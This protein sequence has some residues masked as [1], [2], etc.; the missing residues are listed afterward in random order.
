[1]PGA[2]A[3]KPVDTAAAHSKLVPSRDLRPRRRLLWGGEMAWG[4]AR[5]RT[6]AAHFSTPS[7]GSVCSPELTQ[8]LV[9]RRAERQLWRERLQRELAARI[10]ASGAPVPII[11]LPRRAA[12]S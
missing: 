3:V 7:P 5:A 4:G 2:G 8:T 10:P 1:M 12:R 11:G 9:L 6:P